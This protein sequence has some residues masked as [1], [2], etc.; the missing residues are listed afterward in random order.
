MRSQTPIAERYGKHMPSPGSVTMFSK[1]RIWFLSAVFF[2]IRCFRS[3]GRDK[4]FKAVTCVSDIS[5]RDNLKSLYLAKL[6]VGPVSCSFFLLYLLPTVL[7]TLPPWIIDMFSLSTFRKKQ[8][9][10]MLENRQRLPLSP[11]SGK[12]ERCWKIH[13]GYF[14]FFSF[15]SDSM[16]APRSVSLC[17]RGCIP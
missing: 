4:P 1:C 10:P 6:L 3:C 5:H 16:K 7:L 2:L 11:S 9:K 15:F 13:D 8:M 14:Q 17:V 12:G